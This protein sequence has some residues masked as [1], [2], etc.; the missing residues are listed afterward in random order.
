MYCIFDMKLAGKFR[1][2][3]ILVVV[4]WSSFWEC[5]V[6]EIIYAIDDGSCNRFFSKEDCRN[7]VVE[8]LFERNV[9]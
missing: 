8:E 1:A 3:N 4:R 5:I 2:E 7:K 9:L 6:V